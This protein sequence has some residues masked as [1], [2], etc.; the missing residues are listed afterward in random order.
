MARYIKEAKPFSERKEEQRRLA[1]KVTLLLNE[2]EEG[3]EDAVRA[4]SQ[5]FDDWSPPSFLLT[6]AEISEAMKQVPPSAVEDIKFARGQIKNFA[7]K[8]KEALR[9]IEVETMPGL[10]LGHKNIPVDSVG[11]YVPGG[12]YPLIVSALMSVVTA[13]TAGVKRIVAATPPHGGRPEPLVIAAMHLAG[14]DEILILGGIQALGAMAFGMQDLSSVSMLVGP[15]NAFVAE[16]KRQLFGRVG[17]DLLAG[18]TETLL[19]ADDSVDGELCAV[20]LLGQAEHGVT[21]PAVLITNSLRLAEDTLGWIKRLLKKMPTAATAA[22]AW[23]EYGAVLLCADHRE[24]LTAAD[25]IASEHVQ[26]MTRDDEFFLNNMTNYGSLFVGPR[27][28]VAY[29]DKVSGPNHILPTR[30][31]AKWSGGLWVGKFIKTCTYQRITDDK[32][33]ASI[34]AFCSRLSMLEGMSGHAEQANIRIRRYGKGKAKPYE[35]AK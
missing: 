3:G 6:A 10:V 2:I 17:I 16:A 33:A 34:G 5:R 25:K 24:M 32:T 27:T 4:L 21:S 8:Q 19:L 7:L 20:D 30:G 1:A 12:G 22:Q 14:A 9:E 35:A 15:G 13:R 23:Q 11:C 26:L 29:G 31:G 18:P 28:N